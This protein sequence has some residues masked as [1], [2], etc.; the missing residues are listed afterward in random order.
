MSSS[1]SNFSALSLCLEFKTKLYSG[2]LDAVTGG[3]HTFT[4]IGFLRASAY[5]FA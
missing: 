2:T 4:L 1:V 3:V 5:A